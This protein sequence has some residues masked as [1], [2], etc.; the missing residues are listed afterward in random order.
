MAY[1]PTP[2]Q[3]QIYCHQYFNKIYNTKLHS[4]G[5]PDFLKAPISR[6]LENEVVPRASNLLARYHATLGLN[7]DDDTIQS[8]AQLIISTVCDMLIKAECEAANYMWNVANINIATLEKLNQDIQNFEYQR[9][10]QAGYGSNQMQYNANN[11]FSHS[12][13]FNTPT[14]NNAVPPGY[15]NVNATLPTNF[16]PILP[17]IAPTQPPPKQDMNKD[18]FLPPTRA[19]DAYYLEPSAGIKEQQPQQQYTPTDIFIKDERKT[20]SL[21]DENTISTSDYMLKTMTEYALASIDNN[22]PTLC[23][24]NIVKYFMVPGNFSNTFTDRLSDI[25]KAQTLD[26]AIDIINGIGNKMLSLWVSRHLCD[27]TVDILKYRYNNTAYS[28]FTWLTS[29]DSCIEFLDDLGI[30]SDVCANLLKFIKELFNQLQ[31][32]DGDIDTTTTTIK[33]ITIMEATIVEPVLILP[34]ATDYRAKNKQL[35][36]FWTYGR[37]DIFDVYHKAFEMVNKFQLYITLFDSLLSEY[38]IWRIGPKLESQSEYIVER[39]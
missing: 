30:R 8:V 10:Q 5:I 27:L 34:W 4:T 14:F 28:R 33:S 1:S 17:A 31:Y 37:E 16:Q 38:R 3:I 22:Q 23:H 13:A 12:P 2:Q 32:S 18:N 29:K 25:P 39:R 26:Q 11:A 6:R 21:T 35:E 24:R 9:Q 7:V 20:P 36:V 19:A 15:G